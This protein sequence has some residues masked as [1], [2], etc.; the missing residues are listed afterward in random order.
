MYTHFLDDENPEKF[1]EMLMIYEANTH[2]FTEEEKQ[3]LH[4]NEMKIDNTSHHLK[5]L[6]SSQHDYEMEDI[7]NETEQNLQDLHD[8]DIDDIMGAA[9]SNDDEKK[10]KLSENN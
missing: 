1:N 7:Y 8:L 2:R 10:N 4:K 9:S 6:N 5:D 3:Q